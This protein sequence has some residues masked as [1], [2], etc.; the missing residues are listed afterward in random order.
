[1]EW[2]SGTKKAVD[3]RADVRYW[4]KG[5]A[6]IEKHPFSDK[7]LRTDS[8]AFTGIYQSLTAAQGADH[9]DR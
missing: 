5:E 1:M 9:E 8:G 3:C 2:T 6:E 4:R 7:Y